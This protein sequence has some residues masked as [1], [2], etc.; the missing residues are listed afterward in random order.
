M[1]SLDRKL[2]RIRSGAYTPADFIIADA[3]DADMALGLTA[4]GPSQ[5]LILDLGTG[6]GGFSGTFGHSANCTNVRCFKRA[7]TALMNSSAPSF[8][9]AD[10]K[11]S[12]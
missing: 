8:V 10:T 4:P 1:K 6:T 12:T 9:A 11:I 3:K 2:A 7:S 5:Q